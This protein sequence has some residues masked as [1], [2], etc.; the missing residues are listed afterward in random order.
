VAEVLTDEQSGRIEQELADLLHRPV[1]QLRAKWRDLYRRAPPSSFG[2]DLL[3]RSIAYRIQ[4]QAYGGL[5]A[6]IRCELERLVKEQNKN[7]ATKLEP[8]RRIKA[9]SVL[10]REWKGRSY[11]VIVGHNE[12]S[13]E[14]ENYS[15]L[16]EIA[17][18]ITGTR[19]NGPRFFG[20]RKFKETEESPVLPTSKRGRRTR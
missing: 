10:V 15:N 11:R 18:K 16:S 1:K 2:R 6:D 20:L 7:P 5:N 3:R 17:R 12:F 13:Y 9:G 14:G 8:I 19:W 4:E